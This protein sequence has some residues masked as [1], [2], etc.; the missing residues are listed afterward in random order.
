MA[1]LAP[2]DHSDRIVCGDALEVLMAPF[3]Y[4]GGKSSIAHEVW[5]AL[6]QPKHYI[7]PFF[8]SGAVLLMRPDY[9]V[10][11][12]IETVNDSDGFVCNVWRALQSAPDEVAK[13]CDWPVNH[14]DLS[15]RKKRLIEN[16]DRLMENL[17]ADDTW[18]DPKLAGYWIWAASCWIG[19]GLTR[20]GQIPHIG[21]RGAG[22]HALGKRP[23]LSDGGKGVQEPYNPNLYTWF[24]GLSERLRHVRVVC[25]DWTRVCGGNWQ[26]NMGDVGIFFD[27]PYGVS[28]RDT[29][30]YH[31]DSID[32]AGAVREWALARGDRPTYRIVIAGYGEHA[33]LLDH[34]WTVKR[35]KAAGGYAKMGNGPSSE[36]RKRECLYLS[37]H[38]QGRQEVLGV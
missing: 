14:A 16:E 18:C 5:A 7:E 25:G 2:G 8:G 6:G 1:I 33:D 12:H 10:G 19:S 13:W 21:N 27:P 30:I 9:Q 38:C 11:V 15:A 20:P 35:W 3:P 31:H 29:D 28:D 22:V 36:N 34:G 32:V 23:H 37:P 26:D 24:R 4:F 17:I